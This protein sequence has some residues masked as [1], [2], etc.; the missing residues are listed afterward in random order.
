MFLFLGNGNSVFIKKS[1]GE[2]IA[3]DA[4][5][6]IFPWKR[7]LTVVSYQCGSVRL[8]EKKS[9]AAEIYSFVVYCPEIAAMAK[10]GQF[11]HILVPGFTLRRPISICEIDR[12]AGT[13]RLVFEVRGAGTKKLSE[14]N[15][16]GELDMIAPLGNGF[17]PVET[18][19]KRVLA[20]GGGIGAPPMLETAK[21]YPNAMAILGFR[22]Y[23]RVILTEDFEKY[24]IRTIL[25]TDDGSVGIH[26]TVAV[27][28]KSELEKRDV[29]AVFACGPLPM[30]RAVQVLAR[31]YGVFCELSLEERMGCGVGACVGCVCRVARGGEEKLLRVCKDGPVFNAEEAILE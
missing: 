4:S 23:R 20:V 9:L 8:I 22:D 2:R 17:S 27:P 7:R 25:C 24:G 5:A 16:G 10:S 13:L 15:V 26:G 11:V 30:L 29:S 28:L 3:A 18:G 14:T 19:G 21:A 1:G 6:R 12:E 31:E